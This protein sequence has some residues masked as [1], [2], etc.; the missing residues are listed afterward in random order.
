MWYYVFSQRK[1]E[2][3]QNL[4]HPPDYSFLSSGGVHSIICWK[5]QSSTEILERIEF[6]TDRVLFAG[7]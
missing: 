6:R 1:E 2:R 3:N 5:S 4:N 7:F